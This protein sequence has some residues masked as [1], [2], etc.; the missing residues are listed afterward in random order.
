MAHGRQKQFIFSSGSIAHW[1]VLLLVLWKRFQ[2]WFLKCINT[3]MKYLNELDLR[4]SY[5]YSILTFRQRS[6]GNQ[7]VYPI[8]IPF[9]EN[10]Q[11]WR[12]HQMEKCVFSV[13]SEPDLSSF[14]SFTHYGRTPEQ[15]T[16]NLK[17]LNRFCHGKICPKMFNFILA[18]QWFHNAPD[19]E[20]YIRHVHTSI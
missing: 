11:I 7:G 20:T 12:A 2:H 10:D 17:T 15:D 5:K 18:Q 8:P 9:Q 13:F 16:G 6:S 19:F 4:W 14:G 3:L 1:K